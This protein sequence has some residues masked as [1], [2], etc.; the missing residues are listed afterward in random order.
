[1]KWRKASQIVTLYTFCS[2]VRPRNKFKADF[3]LSQ[4]I[5]KNMTI[6]LP[7]NVS[8]SSNFLAIQMSLAT[9]LLTVAT[10]RPLLFWFVTQLKFVGVYRSFRTA[11]P[12]HLQGS[13]VNC[14]TLEDGTEGPSR[15]VGKQSPT[16]AARNPE[17][18]GPHLQAVEAINFATVSG[19]RAVNGLAFLA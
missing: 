6:C 13:R 12:S 19:F 10:M 4:T 18:Q 5:V 9:C 14:L 1:M 17:E 11:Y 16:Y 7:V 15:N 3:C 8:W 2:S